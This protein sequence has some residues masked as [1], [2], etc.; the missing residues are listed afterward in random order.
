MCERVFFQTIAQHVYIRF[1]TILGYIVVE[2]FPSGNMHSNSYSEDAQARQAVQCMQH[3][4]TN[5]KLST[6][7]PPMLALWTVLEQL[8][9]VVKRTLS[10]FTLPTLSAVSKILF[11]KMSATLETLPWIDSTTR[12][13]FP[14]WYCN[15]SATRAT[16]QRENMAHESFQNWGI[17]QLGQGF[18][19]SHIT[20]CALQH[21][22]L[23]KSLWYKKCSVDPPWTDICVLYPQN[24]GW[25]QPR[26]HCLK[27]L[28]RHKKTLPRWQCV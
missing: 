9:V 10:M 14:G 22:E 17:W 18:A 24:D 4:C 20:R 6:S 26:E 21:K 27:Q 12:I 7:G 5:H 16:Q 11:M 25:D 15:N 23:S 3:S 13:S 28:T 19:S 1:S 8:F 2:Y